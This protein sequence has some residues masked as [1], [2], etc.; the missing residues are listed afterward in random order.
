MNFSFYPLV[1]LVYLLKSIDHIYIVCVAS[2]LVSICIFLFLYFY[3]F[4]QRGNPAL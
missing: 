3:V 1:S 2:I 4:L